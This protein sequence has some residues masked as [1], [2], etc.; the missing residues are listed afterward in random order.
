MGTEVPCGLLT[1]K[2]LHHRFVCGLAPQEGSPWQGL[3]LPLRTGLGFQEGYRVIPV[4]GVDRAFCRQP[5]GDGHPWWWGR[6]SVNRWPVPAQ[7]A[8]ITA[9]RGQSHALHSPLAVDGPRRGGA[10]ARAWPS[11]RPTRPRTDTRVLEHRVWGDAAR[12]PVRWGN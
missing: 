10:S 2:G 8:G 4:L 9:G 12:A 5:L 7:D 3:A 1:P 11:E 6:R